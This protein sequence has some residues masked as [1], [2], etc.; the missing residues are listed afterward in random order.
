MGTDNGDAR[1]GS[2]RRRR[3]GAPGPGNRF[4][5][6]RVLSRHADCTP[7]ILPDIARP[8]ILPALIPDNC[9]K[10]IKFLKCSRAKEGLEFSTLAVI[11]NMN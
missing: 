6:P 10:I 5:N 2:P 1:R 11:L 3:C 4:R 7:R 9:W 8:K